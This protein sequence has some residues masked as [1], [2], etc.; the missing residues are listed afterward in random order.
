MRDSKLARLIAAIAG[1]A[2]F[3][4]ACQDKDI[5]PDA[6]ETPPLA[7]FAISVTPGEAGVTVL[8]DASESNDVQ[9]APGAL[10]VR[11]DWQADGAWDTEFSNAKTATH[12]YAAGE[13]ATI[14]VEVRDTSGLTRTATQFASFVAPLSCAIVALPLSGTAPLTVD[15]AA[16]GFGGTGAYA[17]KWRFGD[18]QTGAQP[19]VSHTFVAAGEY[20]VLLTVTDAGLPG[21]FCSDSVR[22]SVEAPSAN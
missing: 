10:M 16:S 12:L 2:L 5:I 17:F 9:D 18:G 8:V 4:A 7:A 13:G 3:C 11:W 22:V 15:I 21:L 19:A 14:R 20:D 1:T 6:I